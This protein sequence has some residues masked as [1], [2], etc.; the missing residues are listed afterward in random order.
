MIAALFRK[1]RTGTLTR[2]VAERTAHNFRQTWVQQ[3]DIVMVTQA[4]IEQAMILVE[5]HGLRGYDSVHLAVALELQVDRQANQ[6]P[7]LTFLS[8]D[9]E[10]L[11]VAAAPGLPTDDP[12]MH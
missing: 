12:N 3:Y 11:R 5:Q 9:I 1:V 2:L 10:Q 6:L 4:H 8:A 7:P